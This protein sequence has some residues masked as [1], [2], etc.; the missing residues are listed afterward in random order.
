MIPVVF[1]STR[2]LTLKHSLPLSQHAT[3]PGLPEYPIL[4]LAVE[5]LPI[6][7]TEITVGLPPEVVHCPRRALLLD[8][9]K[10]REIRRMQ[11]YREDEFC[12]RVGHEREDAYA[13]EEFW[14]IPLIQL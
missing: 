13:K 5:A 4:K 14:H 1:G 11:T 10:P 8:K 6:R 3:F 7:F 2:K 9:K 12:L